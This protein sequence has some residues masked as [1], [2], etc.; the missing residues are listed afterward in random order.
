MRHVFTKL[1]IIL[2]MITI[3]YTNSFAQ[4][5][6]LIHY[7]G[8]LKNSEGIPFSGTTNLQFS[9]YKT[10]AS[11]QPIWTEVHENVEVSDG[12]YE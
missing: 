11:E 12:D 1:N 3:L 2:A 5:T 8:V 9:L 7:Q 4:G 10:P 6:R